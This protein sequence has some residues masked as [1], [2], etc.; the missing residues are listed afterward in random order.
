[1]ATVVLLNINHAFAEQVHLNC[2]TVNSGLLIDGF[3]EDFYRTEYPDT[4]QSIQEGGSLSWQVDLDLENRSGRIE[5][6][7]DAWFR[8]DAR[9][10]ARHLSI[11]E[12]KIE[13]GNWSTGLVIGAET[14]F[15][16]SIDRT[17]LA[18]RGIIS[19]GYVS[20]FD[21]NCVLV[22]ERAPIERQF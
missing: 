7:T 11:G 15:F 19:S 9:D 13:F 5:R 14:G 17:T 16:F 22:E 4:W 2:E 21:G 20:N 6:W 8:E 1:M 12:E 10:P 18:A 3:A